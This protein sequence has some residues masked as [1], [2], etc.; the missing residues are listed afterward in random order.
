MDL[1]VLIPS[2]NEEWLLATIESVRAAIRRKTEIIVVCDGSWPVEALPD[3]PNVHLLYHPVPVG[4]RAATNEAARIA[5]GRFIMKLDAHCAVDE[6]FDEK[7]LHPYECGELDRDATS[8]PRLYNLHAFDWVCETCGTHFYQGP[9]RTACH[10]GCAGTTFHKEQVFLPKR[11][12]ATDYMRFD[13][14]LHFQYWRHYKYRPEAQGDLIDLLSN[15]GACWMLERDRFFELGG[16]DEAHG[17]W[18]QL[19]TEISCKSWLSGGRL[20]MNKRTWYSHLFRTQPGFSFPYHQDQRQIDHSRVYSRQLFLENTW[21]GQIRP[22]SW[23]IRKFHPVP[24]FDDPGPPP[25]IGVLYFTDSELD[26]PWATRCRTQLQKVL[27]DQ[28]L[29]SVSRTPLA[30]G[31]NVCVP[32]ERGRLQMFRQILAGLDALHTDYV[33]LCEHDCLYPAEHFAI[34]PPRDDAFYYDAN[35]WRVDVKTFQAVTYR[36]HS[37]SG[38]CA[39]RALLLAHYRDLVA[40]V[41]ASGYHHAEG[42]EPGLGTPK[43][44]TWRA[45]VPYVDLRHGKNLTESRWSPEAFRDT[46][47]CQDWETAVEVPGWGP[48]AAWLSEGA[49]AELRPARL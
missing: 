43:L 29:V 20:V 25:T 18:G 7:L 30:F 46:R 45:R 12:L 27:T 32:G 41:A 49:H 39:S 5:H 16:L 4:Q 47:T 6:G 26:E 34:I 3:Y 2:R 14:T 36:M 31:R 19:G 21:E 15:L 38:L 44:K 42:Y 33:F 22:F 37:V 17:S 23:L 35:V 8:V 11:Q 24:T 40:R 1:S 13:N 28:D 9:A 10:E 48:P